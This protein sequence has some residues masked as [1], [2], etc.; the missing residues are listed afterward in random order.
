[1]PPVV[2]NVEILLDAAFQLDRP[3][4]QRRNTQKNV[5]K[6]ANMLKERLKHCRFS[7]LTDVRTVSY[8]LTESSY[9]MAD[10][11]QTLHSVADLL[12]E[13]EL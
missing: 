1:M 11:D 4:L 12:D 7:G 3:M 2:T 8:E 9:F 13:N 10:S 6:F 5:N